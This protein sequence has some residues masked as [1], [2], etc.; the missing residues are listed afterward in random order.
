M[1]KLLA[2]TLSL[3][4]VVSY[5]QPIVSPLDKM[6]IPPS[7]KHQIEKRRAEEKTKGFYEQ[8]NEYAKYLLR[9]NKH[10][11]EREI[12][13][14]ET[15]KD[16]YDNH[17]KRSANDS[18]LAFNFSLPTIPEA[19]KIGYVGGGSHIKDKGW[20]AVK[21]FFTQPEI[22]VC[23]Y[24]HF[25]LKL[26]H[27]YIEIP[28]ETTGNIVNNKYS[29]LDVEGTANTGYLYTVSWYTSETMQILECANK[30]YD[31]E[32]ANKSIELAKRIDRDIVI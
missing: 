21:L 15:H 23:S 5:A 2:I 32:I 20:T 13:Y 11:A 24:S 22:G 16:P 12:A 19:D 30:I 27:G 28:K 7:I 18:H 29:S 6:S 17:F 4:S 9:L 31:K 14:F 3:C 26:S 25:N 1:Y 8:D 10:K